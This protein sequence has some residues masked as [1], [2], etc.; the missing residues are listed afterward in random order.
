MALGLREGQVREERCVDGVELDTAA[1][2]AVS[3][4]LLLSALCGRGE[5]CLLEDAVDTVRHTL[6]R[7]PLSQQILT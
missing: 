5:F 3:S 2:S 7:L 6:L 1:S 4:T